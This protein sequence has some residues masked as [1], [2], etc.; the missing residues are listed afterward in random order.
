MTLGTLV[1]LP[2]L[3]AVPT[4]NGVVVTKKFLDGMV[5]YSQRWDG[6]VKAVLNVSHETTNNLD[7]VE[8]IPGSLPFQVECAEF[9]TE[10][11]YEHLKGAA[12]VLGG[13]HYQLHGLSRRLR[14][15]GIKSVP[16][17]EY[18]YKTR[19][20]IARMGTNS[21][22]KLA[23]QAVWE[24]REEYR[25]RKGISEADG[26]QCNGTPTYN[27]YRKINRSPHLYFDTRTSE[28]MF[29]TVQDVE[30]KNAYRC[31]GNPLR[32]AFSGRLLEIKG[33]HYLVPMA[34]A[35]KKLVGRFEMTICGGG[36]L[37]ESIVR[38]IQQSGLAEHVRYA[39]VLDFDQGL[40]PM[41]REKIDVFVAPHMQGDPSCT[42]LETLACGVPIV[43]FDN[44]AWSGLLT[45]APNIGWS[46]PM[47][48]AEKLAHRI[49]RLHHYR[50]AIATA[51]HAAL[52]FARDH[53]FEKTFDRRIQHLADL[54]TGR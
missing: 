10:T 19:L 14:S 13:P 16:C 8:V 11:L 52:E 48:D 12:V 21:L 18:S 49:F 33:A 5:S 24:A 34:R 46:V 23:K 28:N 3:S 41:L 42:Y 31:A 47:G 53:S 29:A 6:P 40:L 7:N 20:Q 50:G 22:R 9:G 27:A 26:V 2:S 36:S 44:E 39:G 1:V 30:K 15:M 17:V 43:G 37:A 51:S 45:V 32:L 35:L 38:D 54:V 25:Y 4:S